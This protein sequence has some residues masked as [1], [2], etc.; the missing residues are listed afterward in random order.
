V[1]SRSPENIHSHFDLGIRKR[2]VLKKIWP[3]KGTYGLRADDSKPTEDA[4]SRHRSGGLSK[5]TQGDFSLNNG[6]P[7]NWVAS[8][9]E[10]IAYRPDIDGLRALAVIAVVL[11][12]GYPT[13]LTGG[14]IGVDVFF[15]ISGFLI[16]GNIFRRIEAGRFTIADF[17]GRRIRRIFPALCLVLTCCLAYGFVVLLPSELARLGQDATAGA[18]FVAN[19]LLWHEAGYFD[20]SA[21]AKPLLHLW[22]LGVE[23]QFYIIWP[24]AMWLLYRQRRH[25]AGP[26]LIIGGVSLVLSLIIVGHSTTADF[27][28]PFT[29]LWE[30]NAGAILAFASLN[31]RDSGASDWRDLMVGQIALADIVS[32]LGITLIFGSSLLLNRTMPFPGYLALLPVVGAVMVIWAGPRAI[33]NRSVL[34]KRPAV[35]IGL[36]SYPLYLWHWPLIS[37]ALIIR[38]EKPLTPL[39]ALILIFVSILLGGLTLR[40]V[41]RPLRFGRNRSR[42]ALLL[43]SCMIGI[44]TSGLA[45]WWAAGFPERYSALPS[46]SSLSVEKIN[47]ALNAGIFKSTS[48]MRTRK[49]DGITVSQIGAGGKPVLFTGDSAIYQYG[50]RVQQLLNEGRLS[51]TVYF[52]VGPSCAPVPGVI[53]G[54]GAFSDCNNLQSV[55]S[56]LIMAEHIDTIVVGASWAGYQMSDC[57]AAWC[58][59][60]VVRGDSRLKI[61]SPTADDAFYAN[62]RDEVGHFLTS[63]HKVYLVLAPAS[64]EQFNPQNMITRSLIG[65]KVDRNALMAVP[66]EALAKASEAINQR[67]T[68]IATVTGANTLNPLPDVCGLGPICSPFFDEGRPKFV[69]GLHLTP[70]FVAHHITIFDRILTDPHPPN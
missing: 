29:R 45:V 64:S 65:F 14:F 53:R 41:E 18:A 4:L 58:D 20:R 68:A 67:L 31:P 19:L 62:L 70:E 42:N 57:R 36:I 22:S 25:N 43:M 59:I 61:D 28:S 8:I 3:H 35:F 37:F 48:S 69:D 33:G 24:L 54:A 10:E 16:S 66:T 34:A 46:L 11:Y 1:E 55:I 21:L 27:Y 5:L 50:P 26:L 40:L 6:V 23:E 2:H 52:V 60:E 12:H 49:V 56:S 44:A 51:R 32:V 30:L 9:R 38:Q 47:V 15:V 13:Y 17:Y 7:P 63:N 39:M